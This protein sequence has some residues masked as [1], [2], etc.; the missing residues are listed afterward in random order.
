MMTIGEDGDHGH[1]PQSLIVIGEANSWWWWW[2][3]WWKQNLVVFKSKSIVG[4]G[5]RIG[6]GGNVNSKD[7]WLC[8]TWS[9][10]SDHHCDDFD[11]RKNNVVVNDID[12]A[13]QWIPRMNG[14][15]LDLIMIIKMLTMIIIRMIASMIMMS[16]HWREAGVPG[17]WQGRQ[18]PPTPHHTCCLTLTKL[19]S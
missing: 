15:A 8:S 10:N 4:G 11:D 1:K 5:V 13:A 12:D 18:E 6:G 3:R 2:W 14:A 9:M 7:E 17:Y 19:S 16:T